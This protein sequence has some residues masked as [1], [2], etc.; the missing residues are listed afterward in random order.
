MAK[1]L[2][3][4]SVLTDIANAIRVKD[5]TTAKMLA[6]AMAGKIS[7]LETGAKVATG[8]FSPTSTGFTTTI[9]VSNVGFEP[10]HIM[11]FYGAAKDLTEDTTKNYL[12]GLAYGKT[13]KY[14]IAKLDNN[15][16]LSFATAF[17]SSNTTLAVTFASGGFTIKGTQPASGVATSAQMRWLLGNY[18][19]VAIG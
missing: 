12:I 15:G 10:T 2:I 8:T 1:G 9:T 7:A 14:L 6:S 13:T 5:G 16:A 18:N 11:V 19:Y 3:D 17:P 4:E